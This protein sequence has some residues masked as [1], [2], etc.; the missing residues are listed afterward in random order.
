MACLAT[1]VN[2][3]VVFLEAGIAINFPLYEVEGWKTVLIF[4]GLIAAFTI[5]NVWC[6]RLVPWFEVLTG[7][8]NIVFFFVMLVTLWV[9]APRN[10]PSFMLQRNVSSG[11]DNY[12]ISWNIGILSQVWNFVGKHT[13]ENPQN[14]MVMC[15]II[16][17][18]KVSSVWFI[19]ERKPRT[20]EL[21]FHAVWSGRSSPMASWAW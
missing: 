20:Q 14:P 13:A 16:K 1:S 18:L 5:V 12:A 7:V 21:W 4:I 9:M 8:L 11:W 17:Y 19:W 2:S 3:F 15:L 10:S 6:F